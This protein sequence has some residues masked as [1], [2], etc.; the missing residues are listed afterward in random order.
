MKCICD[1][2]GW[3]YDKKARA[4]DLLKVLKQNH[5]FPEY[6]GN[7]FD[8][9]L[10]VLKTGLPEVRNNEGSHGQ[11][12]VIA[13]PESL[14]RIQYLRT[15]EDFAPGNAAFFFHED[16]DPV[17][18]DAAAGYARAAKL[19]YERN[20]LVWLAPVGATHQ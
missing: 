11:G 19:D 12:W 5:L 1:A 17:W 8:Q 3:T 18:K 6:L 9:L 7:T 2:L 13:V 20:H 16:G 10:A 15:M 14:A 4:S